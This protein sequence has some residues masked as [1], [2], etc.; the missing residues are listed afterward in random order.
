MNSQGKYFT[1]S[2]ALLVI[3]LQSAGA[4]S[5]TTPA[6]NSRSNKVDP[7]NR[8]ATADDQKE[9][10]ADRTLTQKIRKSVVSDDSLST[11]AHNIKIVS[12]NG[13]V[14]LNGVV[15]S[16]KE[17]NSVAMKAAAV[18]GKDRVVNELKIAN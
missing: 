10:E 13:T 6:D 17:K 1:L 15:R 11:Y 9:N 5:P 4:Q 7:T 2:A 16:E 12:V 14:T 8:I 18:A 3:A